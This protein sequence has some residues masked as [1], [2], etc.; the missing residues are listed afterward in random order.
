VNARRETARA[1]ASI[2]S[3]HRS[4]RETALL[5]F[6]RGLLQCGDRFSMSFQL[7]ERQTELQRRLGV[8]A[9]RGEQ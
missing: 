5:R 9:V 4:I 3:H 1:T 8:P 6:F 7:Q 2:V